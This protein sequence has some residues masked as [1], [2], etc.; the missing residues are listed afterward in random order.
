MKVIMKNIL[1]ILYIFIGCNS[2]YSASWQKCMPRFFF[3]QATKNCKNTTATAITQAADLANSTCPSY[4]NNIKLGLAITGTASCFC[5]I[6]AYILAKEEYEHCTKP[7]ALEFANTML[8]YALL[9]PIGLF[10]RIE[11]S[12]PQRQPRK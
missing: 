6:P 4:K 1:L 2:T 12:R 8:Q 10:N 5:I 9:M 11:E 7:T 3:A